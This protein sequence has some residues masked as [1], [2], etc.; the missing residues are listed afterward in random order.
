[1]DSTEQLCDFRK[2]Q[3]VTMDRDWGNYSKVWVA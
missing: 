3:H 1:M 2:D